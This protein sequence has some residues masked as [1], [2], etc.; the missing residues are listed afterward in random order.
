VAYLGENAPRVI[1]AG[2]FNSAPTDQPLNGFPTPYQQLSAAYADTWELRPGKPNGFT[3]CQ[4]ADLLNAESAHDRRIDIVF[5][6]PAP[7]TVKANVMDAD[8]DDK[9]ASGLWP[10][11]HASVI[12]ELSYD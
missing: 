8:A 9:T 10:S 11:D 2:D 12:T 6:A 4:A 1:L 3:C 5:A 7:S